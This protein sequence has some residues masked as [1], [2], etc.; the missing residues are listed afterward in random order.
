[1]VEEKVRNKRRGERPMAMVLI[2]GA[3]EGRGR[4]GNWT[5]DCY[6]L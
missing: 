1:M 6:P 3:L 2:N 5:R 4:C